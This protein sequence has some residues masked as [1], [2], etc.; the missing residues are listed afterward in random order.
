M[1]FFQWIDNYSITFCSI[2]WLSI[3]NFDFYFAHFNDILRD[4][5]P[6]EPKPEGGLATFYDVAVPDEDEG[7]KNEGNSLIAF[8]HPRPC[9][10]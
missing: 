4:E 9:L 2:Y 10:F 6:I 3:L 7:S 1:H 8:S 5:D